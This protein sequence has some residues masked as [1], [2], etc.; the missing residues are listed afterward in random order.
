MRRIGRL[1]ANLA[2]LGALLLVGLAIVLFAAEQSGFLRGEIES[3]LSR[4]LGERGAD[5]EI[6]TAKLR[7]FR[8]GIELEGLRLG[9]PDPD[10]RTA[11]S[12]DQIWIDFNVDLQPGLLQGQGL[13][14]E[15]A[16]VQGVRLQLGDPLWSTGEP[17][18]VPSWLL[19][20]DMWPSLSLRDVV[21][22][23]EDASMGSLPLGS[24]DAWLSPR[25]RG[26]ARSARAP[27][28]RLPRR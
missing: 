24:F 4:A 6:D 27:A 23:W 26:C 8:P 9:A 21:L 16:D 15:R 2:L 19:D 7:W 1:L 17:A 5:L 11:L 28:P 3:R 20:E 13:R 18:Q 25:T 22:D 14:I 12:A 10:G